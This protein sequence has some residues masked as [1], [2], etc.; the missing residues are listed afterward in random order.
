MINAREKWN[1]DIKAMFTYTK[2]AM[3]M[4]DI[5]SLH[6]SELLHKDSKRQTF[7]EPTMDILKERVQEPKN[8]LL[9][10]FIIIKSVKEFMLHYFQRS[11]YI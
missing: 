3:Q 4:K 5:G 11:E 1:S 2:M 7:R 10:T 8:L 6:L 9:Q